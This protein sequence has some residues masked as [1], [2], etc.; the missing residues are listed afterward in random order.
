[1]RRL[2]CLLIV[3]SGLYSP[4]HY[5]GNGNIVAKKAE[6]EEAIKKVMLY[7][8][9]MIQKKECNICKEHKKENTN[10][11]WSPCRKDNWL[12][13]ECK[14]GTPYSIT[15]FVPNLFARDKYG[16]IPLS[17]AIFRARKEG[18]IY[19]SCLMVEAI[20]KSVG[21]HALN[22]LLLAD[23]YGCS[24]WMH[25]IYSDNVEVVKTIVSAVVNHVEDPKEA[26]WKLLTNQDSGGKRLLHGRTAR[27]N[28][29]LTPLM[30]A[31]KRKN[32]E[33]IQLLKH[34]A[35]NRF[36][37]YLLMKGGWGE[38]ASSFADNNDEILH[39]LFI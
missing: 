32:I 14:T 2:Y 23:H 11:L 9:S 31:I 12:H 3:M 19:N 38:T 15:F 33:L 10:P 30:V 34:F 1:M 18:E 16:V 22:M 28:R 35:G 27:H 37:E 21:K 24:T 5:A 4:Y 17:K 36:Q 8:Q 29:K 26:V 20:M 39:I 13:K 25:A 6:E 7:R